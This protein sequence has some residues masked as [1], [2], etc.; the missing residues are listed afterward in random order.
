MTAV[1]RLL[2]AFL[3]IGTAALLLLVVTTYEPRR[4]AR[5]SDMA[6]ATVAHPRMKERCETSGGAGGARTTTCYWTLTLDDKKKLSWPWPDPRGDVRAADAYLRTVSPI[7]VRFWRGTVYEI[8]ENDGEVYLHYDDAA[9]W[10]RG[11]QLFWL[12]T[13]TA[14]VFAGGCRVAVEL[15]RLQRG[16][17][18]FRHEERIAWLDGISVVGAL[19]LLCAGEGRIWWGAIG[20]GLFAGAADLLGRAAPPPAGGRCEPA[21]TAELP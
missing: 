7:R 16:F 11:R 12:A 17:P 21:R 15:V 18:A 8:R 10:E 13:G 2:I 4:V 1:S 14:V 5:V 19:S 9:G 3:V 6:E 20:L